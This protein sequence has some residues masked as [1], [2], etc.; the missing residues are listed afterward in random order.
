M[1]WYNVWG[2]RVFNVLLYIGEIMV[3]NN[4]IKMGGNGLPLN[5]ELAIT[6]AILLCHIIIIMKLYLML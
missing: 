3:P 4:G 2:Y 6:F 1:Q 5:R